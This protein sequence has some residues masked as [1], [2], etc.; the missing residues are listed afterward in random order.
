MNDLDVVEAVQA[1]HAVLANL[2]E[3]Y[4]YDFS[5]LLNLEVGE[6]GRF[7]YP[8]LSLYW[9][10]SD[11]HAFLIRK[12]GKLAGLALVQKVEEVWDIAEFF[13]LRAYRRKGVAKHAAKEVW[14]R[15]PGEWRV[16]V[17]DRNLPALRFWELAIAEFAGREVQPI[18]TQVEGED[19]S[20]FSF[21]SKG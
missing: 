14:S 11:R 1:D 2:L 4:V 15:F 6:S 10:E 9:S 17:R 5:E 20:F 8:G 7:D 3:F 13:V 12:D 19:W 21:E 18:A 16:R